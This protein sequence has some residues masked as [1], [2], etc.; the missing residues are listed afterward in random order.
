[1]GVEP[2]SAYIALVISGPTPQASMPISQPGSTSHSRSTIQPAHFNRLHHAGGSAR[3][4]PRTWKTCLVKSTPSRASFMTSP[5]HSATGD[6]TAP[7]LALDAVG[8]GRGPS[9]RFGSIAEL[10]GPRSGRDA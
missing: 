1:M 8:V 7:A 10:A 6:Y 4:M 2:T 5:P 9:H 3:S